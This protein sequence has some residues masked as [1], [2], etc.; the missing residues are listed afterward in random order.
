VNPLPPDAYFS[1]RSK[2]GAGWDAAYE[3][4]ERAARSPYL[5]LRGLHA[6]QLVHCAEPEQ[7]ASLA[8]RMGEFADAFATASGTRLEILNLGGGF[9]SRFMLQRG[10]HT[11]GDFAAAAHDALAGTPRIH[12][13]LEPGR[14]IFADAALVLTEVQGTKRKDGA[15]WLITQ[16]GSNVLPA[17]S[18]RAYPP[19]PLQLEAEQ[20]WQR[21][22]VADSTPGPSRLY[23]DALLPTDA[24]AHGLALI[25][26]GAYT[27]VRASLWGTDLPDIALLNNGAA[28]LV[29]DQSG[30]D[31]AVRHLYG[32]DLD[33]A[34]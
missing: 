13:L 6:H 2:L 3:L 20:P 1:D 34:N 28:E 10:G 27:A 7:F 22:H 18:D 21:C 8:R 9:E 14:Y 30:Q 33:S 23:L 29:F 25:G 11:I 16:V 5:Y 32:V 17:T 19:L 4:L 24:A 15:E 31:A 12:L 26:C